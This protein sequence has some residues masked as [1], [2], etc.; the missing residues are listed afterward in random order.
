MKKDELQAA[1]G[2]DRGE[3]GSGVASVKDAAATPAVVGSGESEAGPSKVVEEDKKGNR[4]LHA[5]GYKG[6]YISS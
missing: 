1:V 6:Q 2:E 4:I 3:G 5:Y